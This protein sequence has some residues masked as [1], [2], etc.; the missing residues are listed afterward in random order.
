MPYFETIKS[1]KIVTMPERV[2]EIPFETFSAISGLRKLAI[3]IK[4]VIPN[5]VKRRYS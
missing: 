3:K 1:E 2:I 5:K 4:A